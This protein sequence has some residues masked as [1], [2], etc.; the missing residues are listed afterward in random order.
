MS[1][2]KLDINITAP[3]M[4]ITEIAWM[5]GV[6]DFK[7]RISTK[8]NPLRNT[9]H[10]T[11]YVETK[12]VQVVKRLAKNTGL[13]PDAQMEKPLRDFMRKGCTLHCPQ[14]HEHVGVLVDNVMPA[15]MRWTI[16]GAGIAVIMESIV[17]FLTEENAAKF[18]NVAQ[19]IVTSTPMFGQGSAMVLT[20]IRRLATMGW[21]L[22]A[23]FA[24]AME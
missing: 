15:M 14:A 24:S 22:P 20:S 6:I 2:N 8:N 11:L 9:P 5:A 3:T 13:K 12:N 17:E 4:P 1:R 18:G 16:T 21:K 10:I 7:G 19:Q 23:K